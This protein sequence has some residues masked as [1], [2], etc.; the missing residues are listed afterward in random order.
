[1]DLPWGA[2]PLE[3]R[4]GGRRRSDKRHARHNEDERVNRDSMIDFLSGLKGSL[5]S[6]LHA[7]GPTNPEAGE[8]QRP[9]S[10][11]YSQQSPHTRWE[12]QL[13]ERH[14]HTQRQHLEQQEE[15]LDEPSPSMHEQHMWHRNMRYLSSRKP[16]KPEWTC[17]QQLEK[18][19]TI[20]SAD[21]E[22]D[23]PS[24]AAAPASAALN[25]LVE[26]SSE[27]AYG[28]EYE[29]QQQQKQHER[30]HHRR[31]PNGMPGRH[32]RRHSYRSDQYQGFDFEYTDGESAQAAGSYDHVSP[33][34]SPRFGRPELD[35]EFSQEPSSR[36]FPVYD[37]RRES[38]QLEEHDE[39]GAYSQPWTDAT[40]PF[41]ASASTAATDV[42]SPSLWDAS[43]TSSVSRRY[44][45]HY[46]LHK[47]QRKCEGVSRQEASW[48][49]DSGPPAYSSELPVDQ[50]VPRRQ[51][52]IE[53]A[54]R[55]PLISE[56]NEEL[57]T[58]QP[59][60]RDLREQLDEGLREA[61]TQDLLEFQ[62]EA[63][64][65][66]RRKSAAK[67][68]LQLPDGEVEEEHHG[69]A[70]AG[71]AVSVEPE[72]K[73]EAEEAA[74]VKAEVVTGTAEASEDPTGADAAQTEQLTA[75]EEGAQAQETEEENREALEESFG[76]SDSEATREQQV[77]S[78]IE[79]V[80]GEEIEELEEPLGT[81]PQSED[82]CAAEEDAACGYEESEWAMTEGESLQVT[83][84]NEEVMEEPQEPEATEATEADDEDAAAHAAAAD[85][86]EIEG[87]A[88]AAEEAAAADTAEEEEEGIL[89]S[90]FTEDEGTLGAN[91]E[92][93]EALSV[94]NKATQC[95]VEE[96]RQNGEA[97]EVAAGIAEEETKEK[98]PPTD[99]QKKEEPLQQPQP[100]SSQG[101][102]AA[103]PE[104][105]SQTEVGSD[106]LTLEAL[107][108]LSVRM[109]QPL[110]F[111]TAQVQQKKQVERGISSWGANLFPHFE[112]GELLPASD[113]C[114]GERQLPREDTDLVYGLLTHR[115]R[116]HQLLLMEATE[117]AAE[118]Q[119][120]PFN[121]FGSSAD[122]FSSNVPPDYRQWA[123]QPSQ[124]APSAAQNAQNA[125]GEGSQMQP[126]AAP[127]VGATQD[128]EIIG[129]SSSLECEESTA[130]AKN[131][132]ECLDSP[133]S[134]KL[135]TG[136]AAS[137]SDK[138]DADA[139][140]K[141]AVSSSKD[142]DSE[143][144]GSSGV[145]ERCRD[146]EDSPSLDLA[147][148]EN[149]GDFLPALAEREE[150]PQALAE[151]TDTERKK[152]D[153]SSADA[154]AASAVEAKAAAEAAAAAKAAAAAATT[155]EAAAL[156]ATR[157]AA[158]A[159]A[160]LKAHA[161][162]AAAAAEKERAA[163][164]LS[165]PEDSPRIPQDQNDIYELQ[166]LHEENIAAAAAQRIISSA[167]NPE[168]LI[169]YDKAKIRLSCG[170]AYVA[171][172][173]AL[174]IPPPARGSKKHHPSPSPIA[175]A[176][177][178]AAIRAVSSAETSKALE[179]VRTLEEN[180]LYPQARLD[181]K[182]C[183]G[184]EGSVGD[185]SQQ[186]LQHKLQQ[187]LRLKMVQQQAN[188]QTLPQLQETQ[189]ILPLQPEQPI[190]KLQQLVLQQQEQ[191]QKA[192]IVS[193]QDGSASTS[194]RASR[195]R[196]ADEALK[197]E[198]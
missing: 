53:I 136:T 34:A 123:P 178:L 54:N 160:A 2:Q 59:R 65:S 175:A 74:D 194:R 5:Q 43:I 114:V 68:K 145:C 33:V 104:R 20:D 169:S 107:R 87:E 11:I 170:S 148:V 101:K 14:R 93:Q 193:P 153:D 46:K 192:Q 86:D 165:P 82:D 106:Q 3:R 195:V 9:G 191:Q 6:A 28:D 159:T 41:P 92:T 99:G 151:P 51:R 111:D 162:A 64:L 77:L 183:S 134:A 128:K 7:P 12:R 16:Q 29:R 49:A 63:F 127:V 198:E 179:T 76:A 32:S 60:L 116:L 52:L 196:F 75:V 83:E 190:L 50:S 108:A 84:Q 139:E 102:V 57:E 156:E 119:K 172:R 164:E 18:T 166:G 184:K 21:E 47:Q 67:A 174:P 163:A 85:D 25:S 180:G 124:E 62:K 182:K 8:Q 90:N 141:V 100:C 26:N 105:E 125:T 72:T 27:V 110:K 146:T 42:N 55:F 129:N 31:R 79:E 177:Q 144:A 39:T 115:A 88:E 89:A 143:A 137:A 78:P 188:L 130:E 23:P 44:H 168:A 118:R 112:K 95:C 121:S 45:Q 154:T 189:Q 132:Q 30:R 138:N 61:L 1:M 80:H 22:D 150:Q 48:L 97:D 133:P 185:S 120:M 38:A 91:P 98:T 126:E 157:A 81:S 113:S 142:A 109:L 24:A 158:A 103:S 69:H 187:Q 96:E 167:V 37:N 35:K 73:E 70:E 161:V 58:A 117:M 36:Q 140:P 19:L 197:N 171:Q 13:Q 155:A 4:R 186:T 66:A 176:P 40:N 135:E 152:V 56:V 173:R 10:M 122:S 149:T 71:M 15:A 17:L 131:A 181:G 94:M 147:A